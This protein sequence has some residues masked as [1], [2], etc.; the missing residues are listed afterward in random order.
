MYLKLFIITLVLLSKNSV[1]QFHSNFEVQELN[2]ADT[3]IGQYSIVLNQLEDKQIIAIGEASHGT[4]EFY[5][6]KSSIIRHLI[7]HERFKTLAFEIDEKIAEQINQYT[8][9]KSKEISST[10]KNYGLYNSEE[11]YNLL[12]WIKQ[13]NSSQ[14]GNSQKILIVGFDREEYWS[15]P[16]TRDSLM[17][18]NFIKKTNKNKTIIW[19]HNSHLVKSNTWDIT[20]SGVKAMGNYLSDHYK[21]DYYVIA[22]DTHSGRLHTIE[23]GLI[24]SFDFNLDK[25]LLPV[26]YPNYILV[27][28][29]NEKPLEY[30]LTSLSSNLKGNPQISPTIIGLDIDALIF[31]KETTASIILK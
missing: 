6:A 2:I 5:T 17:S 31:I 16:F 30:N 21:N 27:H 12:S 1:A 24:E 3:S 20:K 8:S 23:N 7:L 15:N 4:Q 19:S 9:G 25:K 14:V 26:I 29:N 13:Y 22:L 11:L 28:N 18:Q 10:L